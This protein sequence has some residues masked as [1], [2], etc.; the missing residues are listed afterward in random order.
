MSEPDVFDELSAY[1]NHEMGWELSSD[2]AMNLAY[3]MDSF[4]QVHD[5]RT[6]PVI[7]FDDSAIK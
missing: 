4:W 1:L 5:D 3:V 7:D 2:D 6:L